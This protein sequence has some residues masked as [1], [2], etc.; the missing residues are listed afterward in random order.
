[1]ERIG[2]NPQSSWVAEIKGPSKL[3][4]L[5]REFLVPALDFSGANSKKTRGVY[6]EYSL[7]R[8]KI[9]EVKARVTWNR[10]EHYFCVVNDEGDI[11]ELPEEEAYRSVGAEM[12]K[13]RE[14]TRAAN[15]KG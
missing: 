6:A 14:T 1:M 5:E 12:R 9:Y 4:R 10:T 7:E 13:E 11:I 8:G 15:K 3:Y 2:N